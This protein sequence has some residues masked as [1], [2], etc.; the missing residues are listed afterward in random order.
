MINQ[1]DLKNQFIVF[2]KFRLTISVWCLYISVIHLSFPLAFILGCFS[3]RE[4]MD[5][6]HESV[7]T[8]AI[9]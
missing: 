2:V 1:S 4:K 3:L 5:V 6:W 7:R 8:V 9:A